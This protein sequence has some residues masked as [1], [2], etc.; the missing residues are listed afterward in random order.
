MNSIKPLICV[1]SSLVIPYVADHPLSEAAVSVWK[2]WQQQRSQIHAP[3]LLRYEIVNA[4]HRYI[5]HEL[6]TG[7]MATFALRSALALPIIFHGDQA[8]HYRA[9]SIALAYGLSVTYDAHYLAL[10]ESLKADFW[11]AER[12]LFTAVHKALPWVHLLGE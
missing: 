8:L 7:E 6:I 1:D 12:R 2:Q 10:A 5:V 4:L 3:L 11:T 9:Q